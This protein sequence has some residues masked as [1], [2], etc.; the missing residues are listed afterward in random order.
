MMKDRKGRKGIM[1][2]VI[3]GAVLLAVIA[4]VLFLTGV[5]GGE[6]DPAPASR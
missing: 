1:T 3:C 2:A 6:K 4:A 5:I